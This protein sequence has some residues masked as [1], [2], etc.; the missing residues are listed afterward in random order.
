MAD[1]K[2]ADIDEII[3]Q[4]DL[5]LDELNDNE[6]DEKQQEKP[7]DSSNESSDDDSSN[8]AEGDKPGDQQP[9]ADNQKPES[10]DQQGELETPEE[11][12]TPLTKEDIQAAFQEVRENERNWT[13]E[14][15]ELTDEV[16]KKYYPD[17]LSNVLIDERTGKEL[18]TPQDVI[19]VTDGSM[20]YEEAWRWLNNEQQK[21]DKKIEEIKDQARNLAETNANFGSGIDR[22]LQ[23]YKPVFEAFEKQG[24]QQKI[25]KAFMKQVK[26]DEGKELVL[27][28]PD[29]EEFYDLMMEP[30]L[31][32]YGN[33]QT[34]K[35]DQNKQPPANDQHTQSVSQIPDSKP[36]IDD[37]LDE[38]GDGDSGKHE[39]DP[40]NA[41]ETLNE[42]FGE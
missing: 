1:N 2:D 20:T 4:E 31:L 37:R 42:L 25:Y 12:P 38:S 13:K 32:A 29:V 26:M 36:S 22:V 16:I 15:D 28:A 10:N 7:D 41:E 14:I 6:S 40:N 5:E 30:Y 24:I 21:L 9:E 19:D 35:A 23:K 39:A 34:N 27:S 3:G 11:K 18:R 17:G 8:E 33:M